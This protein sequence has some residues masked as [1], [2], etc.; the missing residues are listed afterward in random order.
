MGQAGAEGPKGRRTTE[1]LPFP[2]PLLLACLLPPLPHAAPQIKR[3]KDGS[4]RVEC[5]EHKKAS[6]Q[7]GMLHQGENAVDWDEDR[8]GALNAANPGL[9]AEY[10]GEVRGGA[11]GVAWCWPGPAPG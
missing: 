7:S 4:A 9:D 2:W 1:R 8:L 5:D 10:D 6:K 3:F 11:A